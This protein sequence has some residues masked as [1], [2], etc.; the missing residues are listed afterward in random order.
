MGQQWLKPRREKD[1]PRKER[2]FPQKHRGRC[3][4]SNADE[5]EVAEEAVN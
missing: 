4:G 5:F 2:T 1:Q 3:N